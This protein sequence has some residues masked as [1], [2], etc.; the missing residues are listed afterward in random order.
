VAGL[1]ELLGQHLRTNRIRLGGLIN[2]PL[3]HYSG[4]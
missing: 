4:L 2:L 3:V 1:R